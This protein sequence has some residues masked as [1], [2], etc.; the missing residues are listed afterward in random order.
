MIK[1]LFTR[2]MAPADALGGGGAGVAEQDTPPNSIGDFMSGLGSLEDTPPEKKP[3]DKPNGESTTKSGGTDDAS[4]SA[5]SGANTD[6]GTGAAD[7]TTTKP[8]AGAAAD[9]ST[10]ADKG[11]ATD[12]KGGAA[13]DD[14]KWPRSSND[15]ET[16]KTRRA[17][18]RSKA[19]K[20]IESRDSQITELQAQVKTLQETAGQASKENPEVKAQVD[21]LNAHIEELTEQIR[22][23]DV[24]QHPKWKAYFGEKEK[25]QTDLATDILGAEK[26]KRFAEIVA[27]PDL[28]GLTEFKKAQMDEF[29]SEL[30]T[31]EQSAIGN[32]TTAL[33][34]LNRQ[35]QAELKRNSEHVAKLKENQDSTQKQA[36]AAREKLFAST[37]ADMSDPKTGLAMFQ[38]K[39]GN[40]DWNKQIDGMVATAR[41]LFFGA[42]DLKAEDIAR[43]AMHAAA[44]PALLKGWE[45]DLAAKDKEISTLQ[46]QVKKLTA[47]QPGGARGGGEG[48]GGEGGG[49][50][51]QRVEPGMTP[52]QATSNLVKQWTSEL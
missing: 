41:R 50:S 1:K 46:E 19:K 6:K 7:K 31:F 52:E 22:I 17:E 9:K 3:E 43:S 39:E 47:A 16:F 10:T 24:T 48:G 33:M 29:I 42:K 13:T 34:L 11:A 27:I 15:W 12:S 40:E 28:P 36:G 37:I 35:K 14:E 8:A 32:V 45:A 49:G 20:E 21:R 2:L 30:S 25:E 4:S 38:K 18:E 51:R 5:A 23:L 44:F 26:G